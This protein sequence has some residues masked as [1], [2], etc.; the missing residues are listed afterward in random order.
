MTPMSDVWS[1]GILLYEV[2]TF[3]KSPY[4]GII[5]GTL[6]QLLQRGYRMQRPEQC[7]STAY[8]IMRSCW[9]EHPRKRPTFTM[10]YQQLDTIL[11]FV[12]NDSALYIKLS[13]ITCC[14]YQTL[15]NNAT[16]AISTSYSIKMRLL[17]HN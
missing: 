3:G 16:K 10:L 1:F 5:V 14:K 13:G 9:H 12:T 17:V 8:K 4:P 2:F 6:P 7:P 11:E 15:V